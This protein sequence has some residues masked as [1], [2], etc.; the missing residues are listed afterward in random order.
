MIRK[1][2]DRPWRLIEASAFEKTLADRVN[3]DFKSHR[4]FCAPEEEVLRLRQFA[5]PIRT[6]RD[7]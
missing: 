3:L 2:R 4:R 5:Y 6:A 7:L 1:R